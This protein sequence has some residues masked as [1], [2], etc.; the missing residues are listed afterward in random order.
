MPRSGVTVLGLGLVLLLAGVLL[1]V[2]NPLGP[3][4][5]AVGPQAIAAGPAESPA[6]APVRPPRRLTVSKP[7]AG[8]ARAFPPAAGTSGAPRVTRGRVAHPERVPFAP[9]SVRF[10]TGSA[11]GAPVDRVGTLADGSLALPEDP[12]RMGWWTG[13]SPAG[14]PYG[15]VVLAGHLDSRLHGLGFAARLAGLRHGDLVILADD[16]RQRRYRVGAR[17]LLPRTRLAELTALFSDR[18]PARLVLLTCGGEYDALARAY[19]D[20]LVVEA[21]PVS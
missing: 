16:D 4:R 7:R 19:S 13:G 20:N 18:G 15:S 14:A 6:S 5:P 3:G 12:R 10:A 1:L 17:Y 11:A 8:A 2:G 9:T 21:T